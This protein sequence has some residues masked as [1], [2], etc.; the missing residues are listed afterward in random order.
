MCVEKRI[1]I[2]FLASIV[3]S[4]L[5]PL[6]PS[7]IHATTSREI[8]IYVVRA[9]D[10]E[11]SWVGNTL[12]VKN[13]ID[14]AVSDAIQ[15]TMVKLPGEI[16][17]VKEI[18]TTYALQQLVLNPPECA[19][20]INTHGE[21]LP[22]PELFAQNDAGS[23]GDAGD[24]FSS[25]T[26]VSTGT[27]SG[28]LEKAIESW[29]SQDW[30]KLYVSSGQTIYI[31]MTPPS[32]A[33][34]D[35]KLYDPNGNLKAS[36]TKWG[37]S[38][39]SITY[40]ATTSGY[41]RIK[42]YIYYGRGD[43]T[44]TLSISG[45]GGGGCPYVYTWNGTQ[46]VPDNNILPQSENPQN[47]G[48]D[49]EDYYKL[50]LPLVP[51]NGKYSILIGE[52]EQEHSY[53]DK[54]V[55]LAVDHEPDTHIAVT[56][57]GQI[58]TY[59]EAVPPISVTDK[60]GSD[61]L[62]L[63][64]KIDEKYYEGYVDDYLIVNFGRINATNAKL[65]LRAD[66]WV[67]FSIFVQILN[68]IGVWQTV[69]V[70]TPRMNWSTIAVD[71]SENIINCATELKVRLYF[72]ANHKI[73]FIGLD[74]SE[75]EEFKVHVGKLI[76]AI[77]SEEGKV[78]K[79]LRKADGE[80]VELTPGQWMKLDYTFPRNVKNARSFIIYA[81]GHYIKALESEYS[82]T[83]T[84]FP[85]PPQWEAW[86]DL[87]A[88][89]CRE[90][91][92]IWVNVVGYPFY[93][94]SNT[95]KISLYTVGEAGLK[96]FL[97]KDVSCYY[98]SDHWAKRG[99]DFGNYG[100]E[101]TYD[102]LSQHDYVETGRPLPKD[103]GL[104]WDCLGYVDTTDGSHV[105]V[106]IAMNKTYTGIFVHN[107]LSADAD[108]DGTANEAEDD[109]LK[110]YIATAMAI[111]E[112]R[113]FIMN[114]TVLTQEWGNTHAA[115]FSVSI[116][117]GSW[118]ER[119]DL[120]TGRHYKSVH[121]IFTIRAHYEDY[122]PWPYYYWY[123]LTYADFELIGSNDV[124]LIIRPSE[125][126]LETGDKN[127]A[128]MN[129]LLWWAVGLTANFFEGTTG[130][131]YGAAIG[132]IPILIEY[133]AP[134]ER[135]SSLKGSHVWANGTDI[136]PDSDDWGTISFSVEVRF[137]GSEGQGW[138]DYTFTV[139]MASWIGYM[140]TETGFIVWRFM[141]LPYTTQLTFSVNWGP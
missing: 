70:V 22:I 106:A 94:V 9:S 87:I 102:A 53:L 13:G 110:G 73:D 51:K 7:T 19:V 96:R 34:F 57:E 4:M 41:W 120:E 48:V 129:D 132:L 119:Y 66:A 111:E 101:W 43:Y 5:L 124:C 76:S 95:E 75:Q 21:V 59:K 2:L 6:F 46:Y 131:V 29:D 78:T 32:G 23:G 133:F 136:D 42:I 121:L 116:R 85:D 127:V 33:D 91:G 65:I 86:M 122:Y 64:E 71:L 62:W 40:T 72:T 103:A 80:Y 24:S 8:N 93:Y 83:D 35:L 47:Q 100:F 45:G 26:P 104:L 141:D 3:F 105:T 90:H 31:T 137:Y 107:G 68:D 10:S 55:L 39:E 49:V 139:K 18:T 89:N 69:A 77:H 115:A 56:P 99:Y 67:K 15:R 30:Y 36:S 11:S 140:Y 74:I 63:L 37:D 60:N 118:D 54:I 81:V 88:K 123:F 58:L 14:A 20:V 125:C 25:A 12:N 38:T 117:P 17:N 108:G 1:K 28:Y 82:S 134:E 112:A 128:L 113:A 114:P 138:K 84:S 44:F 135:S 92:W 50:E 52:F 79:M 97:G 109:W 98:Y 130:I 27:H 61:V 126:G 16:I